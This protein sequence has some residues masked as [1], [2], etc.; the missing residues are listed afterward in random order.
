MTQNDLMKHAAE[1]PSG[2][3]F[4]RCALQVNP[5]EYVQ[6]HKKPTKLS[7]EAAYNAA[8]VDAC[9]ENGIEVIAVTDHYQVQTAAGL[10]KAAQERDLHIF[11]GFEAVS[12]DGV[13]FLC[14]FDASIEPK[15]LERVIGDCGVHSHDVPSPTGDIYAADFPRQVHDW[16]GICIAAH[17][18]SKG[19]LLYALSAGARMD[20][21][22]SRHLLACSLPGPIAAAPEELRP[23]LENKN[24]DYRRERP[25]AVVNAQ[26]VQD[27][28][29]LKSGGAT[30]FIKMSEISVEGLRQAFLDPESR[31]RLESDPTPEEHTKFVTLAWQAG[32]LGGSAI[33]FNENL[34]VLIGGRGTGKSTVIESIRYVLGLEPLGDE[35]RNAHEGI[36]R[37]V[38]RSGTKISLMVRSYRPAERAYLLER[39]VPNPPVVRDESGKVLDLVPSDV[40]PN[41]EVFGQHEISEL[42]RSRDKL[43][44]LLGRFVQEDHTLSQ[45]K[46]DLRRELERSR[47]GISNVAK[48]VSDVEER[49][50]SLPALEETLARFEDLEL[51]EKLREKSLLVREE[52]I[53]KT[54]R[55][56]MTPFSEL[57]E[58]LRREIPLDTVFLSPKALESLPGSEILA[59]ARAAL[60]GL[61][62]DLE[63][64][65]GSMDKALADAADKLANVEKRWAGRRTMVQADYEEILRELQQSKVDGEEFINLRRQIE[66]L[67]PLKEREITL[68]REE[69]EL[70]ERRRNLLAEWE[71][72]L[73]EEFRGLERA[74]KK[75]TKQLAGRVR[76]KV[77]FARNR[78]PLV[79]L[80]KKRLGGRFAETNDAID[81]H[82][83]LSVKAFAEA[84][85]EEPGGLEKKY[86]I[87]RAQA[88]R[89]RQAPPD[90]HM[91]IEEL[92]LMSTTS[93]QLN[94][95]GEGQDAAW[96][97]LGELS[98]GQKATAVLLLLLLESDAPL[99]VDQPEDDLD[100]RFI[101]EGIVPKMR[102][103]K[104]RRQFIF[105]THN[106]NIP[107]LGDAELITGLRASG[108]A[109]EGR[110]EIPVEHM[111]SIDNR[112]VRELVE[113][114][115]E[116]GRE[117][118]EWRRV[119][120][121]F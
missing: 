104:R 87:P 102:E 106:A 47:T 82:T 60:D 74:A 49:L 9:V 113:E 97:D 43:T 76:V 48:E 37:H 70:M 54:T 101:S 121:G 73:T 114:V 46:A 64:V 59:D 18:A 90:L 1:L 36:I 116:G 63:R 10:W 95:A 119:K 15:R 2:G 62:E 103:E 89:L 44:R 120:Y 58:Q 16:G 7:D 88:D 67:K 52:R 71:D 65:A 40:V 57:L 13:H 38:L 27:P 69:K 112:A 92:D 5:F 32:F 80:L 84:C 51:E 98:T 14:L 68:R 75:V 93:V 31:I 28:S 23:I 8:I 109:G 118:F 4:Y 56:R 34:N 29:D 77:Q 11:P 100:N 111:G 33:H 30:C 39:T 79:K 6:R 107:V 108:E 117:A 86:K 21:W 91:E 85:R 19:G 99:V 50:A 22:K 78:E 53:L 12:K 110:A 35:A 41:V 81:R 66:E 115:L 17:V 94:V 3:R 24:A 72:T 96:Q 25:M 83:S 42:T 61:S 20:A 26:D 105:A 45:R 55:A